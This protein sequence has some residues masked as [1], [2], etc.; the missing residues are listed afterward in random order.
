MKDKTIILTKKHKIQT[1]KKNPEIKILVGYHKP[2]VL[3]KNE[4]IIPIHLGRALATEESKDGIMDARDYQWMLSNMIG[5]DTGENISHLNRF[6][7]ELTGIYWAWK[8]YDKLDA[9]DYIGF[10]HY[11]RHFV[12]NSKLKDILKPKK[13][14]CYVRYQKINT[15]YLDDIDVT[16][17]AILE[18]V[19]D[20]AAVFPRPVELDSN[21]QEEWE[22]M[23]KDCYLEQSDFD[24]ALQILSDLFPEY[25]KCAEQYLVSTKHYVCNSFIMAKDMFFK[26]CGWIFPILER[27]HSNIDY[28]YKNLTSLRT[29]AFIAERLTGIFCY[30]TVLEAKKE[31]INFLPFTRV[32]DT[33]GVTANTA[34]IEPVYDGNAIVFSSDDNYSPYLG[35]AIQSLIKN[36]KNNEKYDI[37]VFHEDIT[38]TNM[39]KLLSEVN[40]EDGIAL[41]FYNVAPLMG[42]FEVNKPFLFYEN[43]HIK[44]AAYYRLLIPQIFEKYE[45]VLYLDT[46]I[47]VCHDVAELF[48][49]KMSNF[50]LAAAKDIRSNFMKNVL[51]MKQLYNYFNSGILLYNVKACIREN[52]SEVCMETLSRIKTPPCLD[53]DVLNSAWEGRVC[54]LPMQWNYLWNLAIKDKNYPLS[55]PRT[56]AEEYQSAERDPYIIH[57][58]D[59]FKP[60]SDPSLPYANIWWDN[61]RTT[62]FYEEILLRTSGSQIKKEITEQYRECQA[63][64]KLALN[65]NQSPACRDKAGTVG[66]ERE[67]PSSLVDKGTLCDVL[68]YPKF[69]YQ[70]LRYRIL[71][72]ITFGK[73]RKHYKGK[74]NH[75]E[76]KLLSIRQIFTENTK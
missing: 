57:Y 58:C 46:D 67:I 39:L 10:M 19:K 47:C 33:S 18:A 68:N 20:R 25:K 23:I 44:R 12:F 1:V 21:V 40:K 17:G 51:K 13:G 42:S 56:Y 62:P 64:E 32:T 53:Q 31:E 66:H 22:R 7:A 6:Y 29:V 38:A 69:R 72:K 2:A 8:N 73:I 52:F 70:Y 74:R 50:L 9:P 45:K 60:W 14:D 48:Q 27:L 26:Y 34:S 24:K 55:T 61:A 76:E 28:K 71:S 30:K 11:R 4:I 75:M 59:C 35:V 49:I 37:C 15:Q 43:G 3:L 65:I 63:K 16:E 36:R 5:D 41:R 54:F